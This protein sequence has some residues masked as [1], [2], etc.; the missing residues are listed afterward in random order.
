VLD[1]LLQ[2]FHLD[3][4]DAAALPW[5]RPIFVLRSANMTRMQAFL[6]QVVKHTPAPTLHIMSHARDEDAIRAM[7]TCA[8]TF[9]PYPTPGP[10]RLDGVPAETLALLRATDFGTVFFLDPGPADDE[11]DDVVGLLAAIAEN[12]TVSFSIEGTFAGTANWRQR[13]RAHAAFLRLVEWYHRRLDPGG[14]D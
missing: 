3:Q 12:R 14:A 6:R 4:V 1:L 13:K 11:L 7:R 5:D 2:D 9:H 8:F 10:Y